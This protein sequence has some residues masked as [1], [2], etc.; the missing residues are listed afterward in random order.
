MVNFLTDRFVLNWSTIL[1]LSFLYTQSGFGQNRFSAKDSEDAW[2][3]I[4]SK[5]WYPTTYAGLR[6]LNLHLIRAGK[7]EKTFATVSGKPDQQSHFLPAME[8]IADTNQPG[9]EAVYKIGRIKDYGPR[10][11]PFLPGIG[12]YFVSIEFAAGQRSHP[13]NPRTDLGIHTDRDPA[14]DPGTAGCFAVSRARHMQQ[15]VKW[16]RKHNPKK[17]V[18]DYGLGT[19]SEQPV[20]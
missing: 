8:S 15:I 10:G 19:L 7:V 4:E 13:K 17:V 18:V 12:R 1:I 9:P 3:L 5:D 16:I 6:N 2:I 11:H 20:L 14:S